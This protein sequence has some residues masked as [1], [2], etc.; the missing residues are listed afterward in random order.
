MVVLK[1]LLALLNILSQG[2]VKSSSM[3]KVFSDFLAIKI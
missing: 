1:A 2:F 3:H